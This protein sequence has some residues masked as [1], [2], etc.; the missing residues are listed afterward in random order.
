MRQGGNGRELKRRK[1]YNNISVKKVS[2]EG[3]YFSGCPVGSAGVMGI[4][5]M[6]ILIIVLVI[7][8]E[9]YFGSHGRE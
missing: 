8:K 5:L 1:D 2:N 9:P 3:S 7:D 6:L 4:M